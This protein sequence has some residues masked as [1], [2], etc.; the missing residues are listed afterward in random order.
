MKITKSY[1]RQIIKEEIDRMQEGDVVNAA[2]R[3]KQAAERPAEQPVGSGDVRTL[4]YDDTMK[5]AER[6]SASKFFS[7]L[8]DLFGQ[9]FARIASGEAENEA[10]AKY[11]SDELVARMKA[12]SGFFAAK[13][14]DIPG[15]SPESREKKNKQEILFKDA[16]A[17]HSPQNTENAFKYLRNLLNSPS[18]TRRVHGTV[19][20]SGKG[21]DWKKEKN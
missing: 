17:K 9:A 8:G 5:K 6:D 3:F 12:K 2:D 10:T 1:L 20:I 16:V 4:K 14:F 11:L 7:E 18:L 15:E 19:S 21:Y 13:Y